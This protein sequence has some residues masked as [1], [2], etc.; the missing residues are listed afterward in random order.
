MSKRQPKWCPKRED[1]TIAEGLIFYNDPTTDTSHYLGYLML[2][3]HGVFDAG[4]GTVDVDPDWVDP[5]NA[6][7]SA[8]EFD[9]IDARME[10]GNELTLYTHKVDWKITSVRTWRGDIVSNELERGSEGRLVFSR[11]NGRRFS[12]GPEHEDTEMITIRR[13]A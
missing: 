7:L 10:I 3:H 1:F 13:I 8:I 12:A 6:R 4:L 5:H 11:P 2:F 9:I